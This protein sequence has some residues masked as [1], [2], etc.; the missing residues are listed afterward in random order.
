MSK[1]RAMESSA[2]RQGQYL[3]F[4][5]GKYRKQKNMPERS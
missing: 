3:D 4:V 5:E 2:H 1:D